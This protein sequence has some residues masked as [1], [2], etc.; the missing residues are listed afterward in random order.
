MAITKLLRLKESARGNKA[1]HLKH[2][3]FYIC[4]PD[5]CGGGV[6][7]GGNAGTRPEIIYETMIENKKYWGKEDGS[8]GFHYVISFPPQLHVSEELAYQIAQDFAGELLGDRFYYAFA[9]HNDQH[10]MHVHITFDSVSKTDG[11]KYHSPKGDWEKKIQPITDRICR[12]YGLPSLEFTD[13]K[14]GK[15]Y[16]QW[17]A[18][19]DNAINRDYGDVS[20]YD[21]IRDDID[22]AIRMSNTFEDALTYLQEHGY[23]VHLGKYLSLKPY[24][25]DRAVRSSRLGEGYTIDEIKQRILFK[26]KNADP[27]EFIRYGLPGEII[28][29]FK[30]KR[31]ENPSW[32]MSEFQR[33]YYRRW[34]NSFLRNQPGKVQP[35]KYNQDV[36][37]IRRLSNAVK[38][39]VDADIRDFDSLEEKWDSVQKEKKALDEQYKY[40]KAKRSFDETARQMERIREEK[41]NL[42]AQEKLLSDLYTFYFD[43]PVPEKEK[44][45]DKK[46]W[47]LERTRITVHKKLILRKEEDGSYL[48]KVPGQNKVVKLSGEDT[49]LYKSGEI[50]SAFLYDDEEYEL[51]DLGGGFLEKAGGSEMK[52]YFSK[53]KDRKKEQRR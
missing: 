8:Q 33:R 46:P 1:A 50:L 30:I 18:D 34:H 41:K 27:E 22:T 53:Q 32:K 2:N 11:L 52:T 43:M 26:E 23:E 35:W 39:M 44:D 3:L 17:K 20:W 49:F 16:G 25:K 48:V 45:N 29:V 38:Y 12:K 9:V 37:R 40:L 13:E 14:K 7:I 5:K 4:D 36:V 31:Q 47:E 10:H 42:A 51:Y 28:A 19:K 6:W 21:L 24:G 15:N